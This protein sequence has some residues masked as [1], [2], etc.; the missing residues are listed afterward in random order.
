MVIKSHIFTNIYT[1]AHVYK[2]VYILYM[3]I[4]AHSIHKNA[5]LIKT[6]HQLVARNTSLCV[7]AVYVCGGE[8]YIER[9]Y[10]CLSFI[11][12]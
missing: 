12:V 5:V 1:L 10:Q 8:A 9:V 3:P 6:N 4:Y 11:Y 2:S 7:C